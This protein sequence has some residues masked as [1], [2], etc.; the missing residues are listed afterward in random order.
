MVGSRG[1]FHADALPRALRKRPQAL[2]RQQAHALPATLPPQHARHA[3]RLSPAVRRRA[4]D[5]PPR[6]RRAGRRHARRTQRRSHQRHG[7]RV[8]REV[9][10][11]SVAARTD[12]APRRGGRREDAACRDCEVLGEACCEACGEACGE[13]RAADAATHGRTGA[14]ECERDATSVTGRHSLCRRVC[15]GSACEVRV[16]SLFDVDWEAWRSCWIRVCRV[17][18]YVSYGTVTTHA[19]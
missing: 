16:E 14:S 6:L 7:L 4:L 5:R 3:R 11:R 1:R 15:G 13:A 9:L 8:H 19:W 10:L 17:I 12:P 18:S 2:P